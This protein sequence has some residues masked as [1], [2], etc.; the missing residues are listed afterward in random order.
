MTI[1]TFLALQE[2]PWA[3]EPPGGTFQRFGPGFVS[4]G[5]ADL[6]RRTAFAIL[7]PTVPAG[8][9]Q[10]AAGEFDLHPP[11]IL[12]KG[13]SLFLISEKRERDVLAQL[14]WQTKAY[15]WGGPVPA[16]FCLWNLLVR[17]GLY[18]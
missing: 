2:N 12:M 10:V 1:S 3:T 13:S 15:I 4:E 17:I 5:E 9:T 18:R 11:V 14:N 7:D 6:Q 8:A 16:L